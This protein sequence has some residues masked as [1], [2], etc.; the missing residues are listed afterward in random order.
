MPQATDPV[1][2]SLNSYQHQQE[3]L[4]KQVMATLVTLKQAKKQQRTIILQTVGFL[5]LAVVISLVF[6]LV[7]V[8]Q[9][10]RLAGSFGSLSGATNEDTTPPQIPMYSAPVEA[11]KEQRL[12]IQGYGEAGSTIVLI[13]NGQ[14]NQEVPANDAGEF[15][16]EFDLEEAENTVALYAKDAAGNESSVG[17]QYRVVFDK[18]APELV[19]ESPEDQKVI[20]NLRERQVEV[21]GDTEPNVKVYLNDRLLFINSEGGFTDKFQLGDGENTLKLRVEDA[22][23]NV[24]EEERKVFFKP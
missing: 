1:Q 10:I 20:T 11:T 14:I 7:I 4:K 9:A 15:T 8:P 24:T 12:S 22:A 13:L 19:W 16:I 21:K 5:V 23:V 18:T 6:V 17:R 3:L 2:T